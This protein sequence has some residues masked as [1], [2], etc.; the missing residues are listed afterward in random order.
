[1]PGTRDTDAPQLLVP[2]PAGIAFTRLLGRSTRFRRTEGEYAVAESVPVL[3]RWLTF[4]TER[5]EHPASSLMLA[6]TDALA[7]HWAAGQ[8][9]AEELNL[10]ALLDPGPAGNVRARGRAEDGCNARG[11]PPV[12]LLSQTA[13]QVAPKLRGPG[14]TGISSQPDAVTSIACPAG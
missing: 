13:R 12:E 11:F 3:G 14:P 6:A 4:F 8:S 7:V 5:T 2:N 9:P 10:G 1:M